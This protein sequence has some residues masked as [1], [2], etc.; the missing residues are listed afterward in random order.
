M[1]L[2]IRS[3]EQELMDSTGD[4]Q[5]VISALRELKKI[6]KFLGGNTI[7]LS[8]IKNIRNKF[9]LDYVK[10]LDAGSG[11]SDIL[12]DPPQLDITSL[13][14]NIVMCR[15]AREN[16][17]AKHI[18]CADAMSLPFHK[19]S[20]DIVHASLFIHHF[21]NQEITQL[22]KKFCNA[23]RYGVIINDLQR[24]RFSYYG[25]KLLTLLFSKNRLVKNDGLVSIRRGFK[26]KELEEIA[27]TIKYKYKLEMRW[28]FRWL[29]II[30]CNERI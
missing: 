11:A 26:R 27:G 12:K 1:N 15:A 14:R 2:K 28:A 23:A 22:L 21:N 3:S 8:G 19:Y 9:N 16:D 18:V 25:F 17:I 7:S 24:S 10:V 20:F 5:E 6:N 29:L 13:D 4:Y 30:Y